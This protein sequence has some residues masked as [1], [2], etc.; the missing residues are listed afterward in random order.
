MEVH[1][2]SYLAIA[3]DNLAISWPR[4]RGTLHKVSMW[5]Q[6]YLKVKPKLTWSCSKLSQSCQ[7]CLKSGPKVVS[8]WQGERQGVVW[9]WRGGMRDG[10]GAQLFGEEFFALKLSNGI[11]C[12]LPMLLMTWCVNWKR[13]WRMGGS[14]IGRDGDGSS[15]QNFF[16]PFLLTFP[17]LSFMMSVTW[18][19][20]A[21]AA[22]KG[23]ISAILQRSEIDGFAFEVNAEHGSPHQEY[24]SIWLANF[25]WFPS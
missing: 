11:V 25:Q 13:Q 18:S 5:P 24:E 22:A 2:I 8:K 20:S 1:I 9:G 4:I 10:E 19:T 3:W 14:V 23:V 16:L 7:C 12:L 21:W 6:S 15:W 17:T